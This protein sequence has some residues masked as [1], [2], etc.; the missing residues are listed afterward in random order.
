MADALMDLVRHGPSKSP[1]VR[2]HVEQAALDRGYAEPGER[3]E[4]DG[5]GP[6]PVTIV[7]RMLDDA[8]VTMVGHDDTGDVTSISSLSR[9]IP[10]KLRR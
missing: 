9:T 2:V 4:I 10:V 8:R 3:C 5:I 6:V 1:D 7:R